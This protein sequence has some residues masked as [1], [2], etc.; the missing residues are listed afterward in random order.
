M[1]RTRRKD[2][3]ES[4]SGSSGCR[5]LVFPFTGSGAYATPGTPTER[6]RLRETGPRSSLLSVRGS[7]VSSTLLK[8]PG[9]RQVEGRRL[10]RCPGINR[11][12]RTH[13][14]NRLARPLPLGSSTVFVLVLTCPC[15]ISR[16]DP[17]PPPPPQ[18]KKSYASFAMYIMST[19]SGTK[20]TRR[21]ETKAMNI[22]VYDE[23]QAA[24]NMMCGFPL[25]WVS[26][27]VI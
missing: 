1:E 27:D 22:Q 26:Q 25:S 9:R 20:I 14:H 8:D 6:S 13:L 21:W 23:G 3:G 19:V 4:P 18:G 11:W 24:R 7:S 5:R 15:P 16:G 12:G 17:P 10:V 2:R